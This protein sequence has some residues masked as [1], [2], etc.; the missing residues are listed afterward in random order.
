MTNPHLFRRAALAAACILGAL[1]PAS[2]EAQSVVVDQGTFEIRVGGEV[3]GSEEFTIRRAGLGTDAT[4]IAHAVVRLTLPDGARELRPMLQ[5][6]PSRGT[7]TGYQLK[8]SGAETTELTLT[9][10]DRR[11]VSLLRSE[12]G[13]EE[14][15]FLARPETR[16]VER[17]VAHQYHFL[18]DL[19]DDD[20]AWVIEPR[21]RRQM[22][23]TRT[24]SRDDTV[25]I[26]G[27]PV[28]AEV[29]TFQGGDEERTVWFDDQGRVL[30]LVIPALDYDA[31]RE[32]LAG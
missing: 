20:E 8:I 28:A 2:A 25:E 31:R 17:W 10:A 22:T 14:R 32:N 26:A 7:A 12:R 5:T 23:L 6:V 4:I 19:D 27:T 11:Y 3:V 29:V 9:L 13:E 24:R 16:I 1:L 30:R 21:T 18:G 15:E